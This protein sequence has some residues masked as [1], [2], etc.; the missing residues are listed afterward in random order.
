MR[1]GI[2]LLDSDNRVVDHQELKVKA[3]KDGSDMS[4]NLVA[5]LNES[6]EDAVVSAVVANI[7]ESAE[8]AIREL[9]KRNS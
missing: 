6:V 3:I 8:V 7:K 4:A 2:C 9:L 1:I 5:D